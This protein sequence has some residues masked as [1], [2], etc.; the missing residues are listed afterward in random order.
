MYQD[1]AGKQE[2]KVTMKKLPISTFMIVFAMYTQTPIMADDQEG[3][4][5]N[6]VEQ[7]EPLVEPVQ[8]KKNLPLHDIIKNQ[9][10]PSQEKIKELELLL[11]KEYNNLDQQAFQSFINDQDEDGKTA[12]NVIA[13]YKYDPALADILIKFGANVNEPDSFNVTPLHLAIA[14]EE[15]ELATTL[16]E[17]GADPLFKNDQEETAIDLARSQATQ[18]ILVNNDIEAH[19]SKE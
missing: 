12:L 9:I 11:K 2:R 6:Q 17:N 1:T 14:K 3:K 5:Q 7:S 10:I 19:N 16:L 15:V 8:K 13:F 4:I 18:A